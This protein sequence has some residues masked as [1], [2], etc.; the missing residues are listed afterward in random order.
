MLATNRAKHNSERK[1]TYHESDKLLIGAIF[2]TIFLGLIA[3]SSASSITAYSKFCDAYYFFKHQL[4]GLFVGMAVFLFLAKVDYRNWK[5][6]AFWFLLGSI[7]LLLLVFIPGLSAHYGKA[8]SWINV[9]GY[10]LQ[11]S[12]FVKL[13]FLIYLSAWLEFRKEELGE[14][15]RGIMPFV[16]L[17]SVLAG[18]M[19]LQPDIGTLS[20]LAATSLIVFFVGGGKLTHILGIILVGIILFLVMLQIK[21]YQMDRI[22]CMINP[23]YSANDVCYQINQSLIAVGS[24]GVLGRGLGESRQ[25]FMYLPEV[26]GDSIFAI[27]AEETGLVFG[28]ILISLFLFI[29]YRGFLIAKNAPDP[30]G[31]NLAIGIVSWISLQAMINIGGIINIIPMTGVPLPLISYGGSA[32][33]SAMAACGIL[34]N[35]SK[36]TKR[37]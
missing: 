16:G 18:L 9:F 31:Q 5:N 26:S 22:R 12:E 15:S 37:T 17:L 25:K 20:I 19:I 29:F 3:L 11:P 10:S 6:Y 2:L 23:D 30:F 21:P 4:F 8:R 33:L 28:V 27:I 34:V 13:S 1:R 14:I 32:I 35:I 36:Q 7:G 24:G